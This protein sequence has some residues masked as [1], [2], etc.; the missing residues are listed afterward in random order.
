MAKDLLNQITNRD[1]SY[2]P[3]RFSE[4]YSELSETRIVVYVR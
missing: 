3:I 1:D 2:R 4:A